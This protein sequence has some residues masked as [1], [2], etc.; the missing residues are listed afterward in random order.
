MPIS[1]S[2]ADNSPETGMVNTHF[3]ITGNNTHDVPTMLTL[4]LS[5][6]NDTSFGSRV[7][8]RKPARIDDHPAP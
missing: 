5:E 1:P 7:M 2:R 8:Y 3:A 4:P 6:T